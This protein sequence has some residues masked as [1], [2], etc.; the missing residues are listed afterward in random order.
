[1]PWAPPPTTKG[2][3]PATI[4]E[5]V[6]PPPIAYSSKTPA[7]RA[8]WGMLGMTGTDAT[9]PEAEVQTV[10]VIDDDQSVREALD[11]LFQ[12]AGYPV[13][14]FCNAAAF[15]A[16]GRSLSSGCLV[17]DVFLPGQNGLD[18]HARLA[19]SGMAMPVIFMTGHGDIPMAVRGVKG[20]AID[21]LP[22][23]FRESDML[24]AVA[25][26]MRRDA[27]QR[28][29]RSRQQHLR[30]RMA[31]LSLRERQVMSLVVTGRMNKQIAFDI[32]V[33]EVT[34]KI[35]RGNAMRKMGA[36][37]LADLVVMAGILDLR[38]TPRAWLG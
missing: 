13:R 14:S 1:M 16:S 7:G 20:G 31:S 26:A 12:S 18:F 35:H 28:E 9:I 23:P 11:A 21:F 19:E 3:G 29:E 27:E 36:R 37:T 2:D 4:G 30:D 22:K 10:H 34:V 25:A 15:V 32:G 8:A 17:L 24:D 5:M 33:S 38:D 6:G